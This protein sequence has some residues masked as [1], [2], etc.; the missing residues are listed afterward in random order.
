MSTRVQGSVVR[1]PSLPL[2]ESDEAA[3]KALRTS[4]SLQDALLALASDPVVAAEASESALLRALLH[5]GLSAV[6]ERAEMD[7]YRALAAD[8]QHE[9]DERR[10]MARRRVP[11]WAH[12]E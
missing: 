8:Y 12:E 11:D 2:T 10:A 9:N 6:Q 5:V 4:P 1:R 3:L 7:G